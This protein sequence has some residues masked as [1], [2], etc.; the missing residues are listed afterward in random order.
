MAVT[1]S[2]TF[3]ALDNFDSFEDYQQGWSG[4][5]V[6]FWVMSLGGGISQM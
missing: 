2:Q 5:G 6:V 1:V 4:D 3:L